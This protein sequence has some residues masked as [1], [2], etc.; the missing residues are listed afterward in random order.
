MATPRKKW[1]KVADSIARDDLSND[2]LA[3]M[4]RLLAMLNTQW[5]RDG[6]DGEE[7]T[8]IALRPVDLMACTGSESLARARRIAG[9]LAVKVGCTVDAVGK[10]TVI[11][12]P[13]CLEFQDWDSRKP[14]KPGGK[15]SPRVAPS[16]TQD[17]RRKTQDAEGGETPAPQARSRS[18]LKAR[19]RGPDTGGELTL[20]TQDP[21]A[22]PID[23]EAAA[24][25]EIQ[26]TARGYVDALGGSK[27]PEAWK[28]TDAMRKR[29]RRVAKQHGPT[30]HVDAFH[31]YA[32]K[33]LSGS[34]PDRWK[35]FD[36]GTVL[37]PSKIEDYLRENAEGSRLGEQRP[38]LGAGSSSE[39]R[40][41]AQTRR[42]AARE[43]ISL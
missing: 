6:L 40:W 21:P 35:S 32:R 1:F 15:S 14:G 18:A 23:V 12:W 25:A 5:A 33:H 19:P 42:I 24:W 30:A 39:P 3:T 13:K 7:A 41:L 29:L 28:L 9:A 8:R 20:L 34:W 37:R 22:D 4:I 2:E 26:A 36:P 17:A 38:Y 11:S 16:E 31:G 10:Q 27:A 43:G